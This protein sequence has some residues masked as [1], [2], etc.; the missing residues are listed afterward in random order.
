M[1]RP[2]KPRVYV[3]MQ[4]P[5]LTHVCKIQQRGHSHQ[6][7]TVSGPVTLCCKALGSSASDLMVSFER[8]PK[9]TADP[10]TADCPGPAVPLWNA[11]P[12]PRYKL[13]IRLT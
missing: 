4:A 5:E 9:T 1:D 11:S 10:P 2:T 3:P 8:P 13:M 6:S 12:E 7:H